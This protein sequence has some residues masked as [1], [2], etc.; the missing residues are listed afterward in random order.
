MVS[1]VAVTLFFFYLGLIPAVLY[2]KQLWVDSAFFLKL[3]EIYHTS[4][5]SKVLCQKYLINTQ[6]EIGQEIYLRISW[7]KKMLCKNWERC[8]SR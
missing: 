5:R 1:L 3:H 2:K 8:C 4:V 7:D 6:L